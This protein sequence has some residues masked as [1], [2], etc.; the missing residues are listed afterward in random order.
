MK[1]TPRKGKGQRIINEHQAE[2]AGSTAQKG[3]Q[4]RRGTESTKREQKRQNNR[5]EEGQD[6][7]EREDS[8]AKRIKLLSGHRSIALPTAISRDLYIW[9][10]LVQHAG[11]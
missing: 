3:T 6:E 1:G 5:K 4:R 10:E 8:K 2:G 9:H 11:P 7:G